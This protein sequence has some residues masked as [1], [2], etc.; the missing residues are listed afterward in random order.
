MELSIDTNALRD[1]V[2]RQINSFFPDAVLANGEFKSATDLAIMRAEKC[3]TVVN[4]KYFTDG[5]T[6]YFNHLNGDQYAMFLYLLANSLYKLKSDLSLCTKVFAL[7]KLLHGIDA[8]YEVELPEFF[9]FVHPLGTVLGRGDYGNYF[10]SYQR[11][12]IGANHGVYPK[13]GEFVTLYPGSSVLGSSLIND[14]CKISTGSIVL[15]QEVPADS[16]YIG[17]P[18]DFVIK[19]SLNPNTFWRI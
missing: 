14:N 15:D 8:Y 18:T 4:S 1:Y 7:N 12:G 6:V 16:I 11:C 17:K 2:T 13:L 10:V 19:K 9:L 3:F 5:R